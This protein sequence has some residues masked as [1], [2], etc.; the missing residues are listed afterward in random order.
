M[1]FTKQY[2]AVLKKMRKEFDDRMMNYLLDNRPKHKIVNKNK[3][4]IARMKQVTKAGHWIKWPFLPTISVW[5]HR[6][7]FKEKKVQRL[8]QQLNY[9]PF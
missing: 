9:L 4:T 2:S 7:F 5:H 1:I 6:T 3:T 8:E